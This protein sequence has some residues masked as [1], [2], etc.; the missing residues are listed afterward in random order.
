MGLALIVEALG[1]L[2]LLV[3]FPQLPR[4]RHHKP[5][6]TTAQWIWRSARV[7]LGVALV[8]RGR[9]RGRHSVKWR[10]PAGQRNQVRACYA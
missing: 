2:I 9:L 8:G 6:E 5:R 10:R 3:M 4:E 7:W 1:A